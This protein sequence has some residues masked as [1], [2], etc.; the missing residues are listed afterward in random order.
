MLTHGSP[1]RSGNRIVQSGC[2]ITD[3]AAKY[4]AR[5]IRRNDPCG[6][7]TWTFALARPG[8]RSRSYGP[9]GRRSQYRRQGVVIPSEYDSQYDVITWACLMVAKKVAGETNS[10][11]LL[12][13]VPP[14]RPL[15][16]AIPLSSL[17]APNSHFHHFH[18]Q[19]IP[20]DA[21]AEY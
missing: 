16:F 15:S 14:L 11:V 6:P 4:V 18:L 10:T 17:R 2:P 21:R 1:R 12:A 13:N 8:R 7:C 5:V 3:P 20:N 9:L 19:F